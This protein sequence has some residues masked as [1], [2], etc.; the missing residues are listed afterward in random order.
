MLPDEAIGGAVAGALRRGE[1]GFKGAPLDRE[2]VGRPLLGEEVPAVAVAFGIENMREKQK[3]QR[4]HIR[5]GNRLLHHGRGVVVGHWGSP[6]SETARRS[7]YGEPG[8][9]GWR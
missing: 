4:R 6:E 7:C 3:L 8:R 2:H 9:G 5:I 1:C